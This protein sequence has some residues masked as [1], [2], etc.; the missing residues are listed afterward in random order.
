MAIKDVEHIVRTCKACQF[1]AII[2]EV[3]GL[4]RSSSR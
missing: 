3:L 1:A 4:H 2:S